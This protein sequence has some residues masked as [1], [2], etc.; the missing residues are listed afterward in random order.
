[1]RQRRAAKP[2][3]NELP[4]ADDMAVQ[5]LDDKELNALLKQAYLEH[6]AADEALAEGAF[7]MLLFEGNDLQQELLS[8][9]HVPVVVAAPAVPTLGA[10]VVAG[11]A[12]APGFRFD[13]ASLVASVTS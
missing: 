9:E 6:Y 10:G 4:N 13:P 11:Q 7:Q 8:P 1:V 12:V 2:G 5:P 3:D